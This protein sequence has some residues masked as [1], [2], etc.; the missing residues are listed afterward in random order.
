VH[1]V[2]L[3]LCICPVLAAICGV[4]MLGWHADE[5]VLLELEIEALYLS[6]LTNALAAQN[7][8]SHAHWFCSAEPN[9]GHLDFGVFADP[10]R[11]SPCS[12]LH[13]WLGWVPGDQKLSQPGR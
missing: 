13:V 4:A 7:Q 8:W 1:H 9:N 6:L 3:H 2:D 10:N 11:L 12:V 5:R